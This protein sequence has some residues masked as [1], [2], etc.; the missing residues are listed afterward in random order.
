[1]E[2]PAIAGDSPVVESGQ[3]PIEYPSTAGH[4]QPGGNLGGPSPKAKYS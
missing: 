2:R 1:M 3:H 4:E